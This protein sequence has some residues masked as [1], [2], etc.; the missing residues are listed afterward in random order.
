MHKPKKLRFCCRTEETT[1]LSLLSSSTGC[2]YLVGE[3]RLVATQ[4]QQP[5]P[6]HHSL[7]G[8]M[9]N[10]ILRA[11]PATKTNSWLL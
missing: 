3:R 10:C 1:Q 7:G 8:E 2:Y 9:E 4:P 6:S 11:E 5:L